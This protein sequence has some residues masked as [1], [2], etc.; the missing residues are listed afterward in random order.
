MLCLMCV[1]SGLAF[2]AAFVWRRG[3]VGSM[4]AGRAEY[5][6]EQGCFVCISL[7]SAV[8][9]DQ[10][11]TLSLLEFVR[12]WVSNLAVACVVC[13]GRHALP[14]ALETVTHTHIQMRLCTPQP[15]MC[16]LKQG[17]MTHPRTFTSV[18]AAPPAVSLSHNRRA[19]FVQQPDAG[20]GWTLK[21]L[22]ARKTANQQERALRIPPCKTYSI[23]TGSQES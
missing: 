1:C 21:P 8:A 9:L 19:P 12:V 3:R 13:L 16:L 15:Q 5:A 22:M 4:P 6:S 11:D 10:P 14:C 7:W 2:T 20:L 17:A 23:C 18:C